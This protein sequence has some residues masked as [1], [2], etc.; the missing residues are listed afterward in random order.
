MVTLGNGVFGNGRRAP[1]VAM[2]LLRLPL[3]RAMFCELIGKKI[4]MFRETNELFLLGPLS[5]IDALLNVRWVDVLPE[6]LMADE[7][8]KALTGRPSRDRPVFEDVLDYESGT[9]E[10]LTHFASHRFA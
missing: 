1:R 7:I 2:G 5:V 3:L 9:W 6:I 4:G 10:Q 8:K